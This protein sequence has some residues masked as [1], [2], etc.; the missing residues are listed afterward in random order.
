MT[1]R[2]D[3]VSRKLQEIYAPL[4]P[5]GELSVF[6]GSNKLYKEHREKDRSIALRHLELSSIINIRRY[7]ISTVSANQHRA[8]LQYML[9]SV[10]ALLAQIELW[11]Q[12]G[13]GSADLGTNRRVQRTLDALEEQLRT[14]CRL[15]LCVCITL[16]MALQGPDLKRVHC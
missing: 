7:C 10:P 11:T 1:T 2:N 6:C 15:V 14:V 4:A 3:D 16:L 9:H 8:A 13:A 12:T 5:N